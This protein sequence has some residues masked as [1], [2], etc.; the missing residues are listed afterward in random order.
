MERADAESSLHRR[1]MAAL[2]RGARAQEH[3]KDLVATHVALD[4]KVRASITEVR[5]RRRNA[6]AARRRA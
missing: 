3:S 4:A 2:A 5:A 1:L 6:Q